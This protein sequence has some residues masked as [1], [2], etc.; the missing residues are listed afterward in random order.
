MVAASKSKSKR[1][2][3][4]RQ[5]NVQRPRKKVSRSYV[6]KYFRNYYKSQQ[7]KVLSKLDD[8]KTNAALKKSIVIKK[9][10]RTVDKIITFNIQKKYLKIL[11]YVFLLLLMIAVRNKE[12][13]APIFSVIKQLFSA[14]KGT[15][16]EKSF[17]DLMKHILS[18][19]VAAVQELSTLK[20]LYMGTALINAFL[21]EIPGIV[22]K[23]NK[24]EDIP[25]TEIFNQIMKNMV[26]LEKVVGDNKKKK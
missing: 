16:K 15:L 9:D 25:F 19:F 8:L 3:A 6:P 11:P 26:D 18:L 24:G 5:K 7:N 1:A 4:P 23:F 14:E 2:Q 12:A 22:S 10:T 21:V 17:G 20:I 13:F